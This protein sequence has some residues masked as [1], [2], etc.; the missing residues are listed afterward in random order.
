MTPKKFPA[1]QKILWTLSFL[2]LVVG[3]SASAQEIMSFQDCLNL[4]LQNNAD[5]R[6]S[7][8]TVESSRYQVDVNKSNYYPALSANAGYAQIGPSSSSAVGAGAGHSYSATLNA[9]QNVFNGFADSAKVDQAKAQV[10]VSEAGLQT[11]KAQIS[12]DLKSSYAGLIYSKDA[13]KVSQEIIKRREENLRMVEL[14]FQSGR[15]NKGSL[16]LSQAYLKQSK[17]DYLKAQH[18]KET[19][20]SDLKKVLGLDDERKLDISESLALVEPSGAEPDYRSVALTNP[21]RLSDLAQVSASEAALTGAKSG[22]FPTLG[23]TASAGQ[24]GTTFYPENDRWTLGA[25]FSWP[26]F[27]GG[28]DYASKHSAAASL[29]TAKS[30]LVSTERGTLS[31][32]KLTY[33]KY[34]ESA[35]ELKVNDAFMQAAKTRAEIARNK[36][37]NGLLTFDDWDLIEND[38]ITKTKTY[39]LSKRDRII[40]EAAWEQA[41]GTG[42]IP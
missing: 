39:I 7:Q 32:L 33:T 8:S 14:R 4:V 26:L 23:L 29:Y 10:R 42:V 37:N 25:N 12:Y 19:S 38:L 31:K 21:D 16:L 35:E 20:T 5:L 17:L 1:F 40:A 18:V 28:K 11:T 30:N 41:Q 34:V 15:E 2:S 3:G 6:S 22:F 9:S 24:L 27:N 13:E 36:Y